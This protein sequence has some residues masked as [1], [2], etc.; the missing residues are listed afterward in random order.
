MRIWF[1]NQQMTL[2][3]DKI[4]LPVHIYQIGAYSQ[5]TCIMKELFDEQLK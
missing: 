4:P 1:E 2:V 3:L 5:T